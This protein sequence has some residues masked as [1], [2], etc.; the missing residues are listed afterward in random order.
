MLQV[1]L[2][3]VIPEGSSLPSKGI[4]KKLPSA[5]S[6]NYK[7]P[8][9]MEKKKFPCA[10]A[11]SLYLTGYCVQVLYRKYPV[12]SYVNCKSK[13]AK[14]PLKMGKKNSC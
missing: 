6:D 9:I 3:E 4:A 8:D 5:A 7:W 10:I 11:G 13:M 1:N 12:M 14:K 2:T